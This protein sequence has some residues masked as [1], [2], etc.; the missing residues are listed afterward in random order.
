MLLKALNIVALL[1][2]LGVGLIASH[3]EAL[4]L[5]S[6]LSLGRPLPR[7]LGVM[8]TEVDIA[9]VSNAEVVPESIGSKVFGGLLGTV[10]V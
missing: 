6:V 5:I 10:R 4:T 2:G 1:A 8:F 3:F 7:N 9:E